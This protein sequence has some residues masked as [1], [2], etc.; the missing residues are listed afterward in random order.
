MFDVLVTVPLLGLFCWPALLGQMLQVARSARCA[1]GKRHRC[2]PHLW[3]LLV[4]LS[5]GM[6][7]LLFLAHHCTGSFALP[8][9]CSGLVAL[10]SAITLLLTRL[11]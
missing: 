6:T 10:A 2:L 7:S 1:G 4:L 3:L 9:G 11:D 8:T 5:L